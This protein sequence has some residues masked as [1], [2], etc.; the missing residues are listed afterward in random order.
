M[1]VCSNGSRFR[2]SCARG[3]CTVA[4]VVLVVFGVVV[5]VVVAILVVVSTGQE[6]VMGPTC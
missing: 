4:V 3:R 1:S 6:L 5:D 2:S